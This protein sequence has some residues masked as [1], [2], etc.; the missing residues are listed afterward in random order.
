MDKKIDQISVQKSNGGHNLLRLEQFLAI[1]PYE[2]TQLVLQKKVTF[3]DEDGEIISLTDGLKALVREVNERKTKS[4]TS[5]TDL[6][7]N[8]KISS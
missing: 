8:E 4:Q 6:P 5:S 1:S 2:R 3:I 7:V